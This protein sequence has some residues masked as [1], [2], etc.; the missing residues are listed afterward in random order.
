MA[1]VF[2][3]MQKYGRAGEKS[4]EQ[5]SSFLEFYNFDND[6]SQ[7]ET[8]SGEILSPT[9]AAG[10]REQ[11]NP[12]VGFAASADLQVGQALDVF[13]DYSDDKTDWGKPETFWSAP[14]QLS[15][16]RQTA[17]TN[18]EAQQS[19]L[20]AESSAEAAFTQA[21][22]AP[23]SDLLAATATEVSTDQ[24][25]ETEV[26]V[27]A[28]AE[29]EDPL[30]EITGAWDVKATESAAPET[31]VESPSPEPT[32][33]AE[34]IIA[35]A[36]MIRSAAPAPAA[37]SSPLVNTLPE[38]VRDEFRRLR[39]SLLLAAESQQLQVLMVCGVES[40]D[41]ATFVARNLSLLLAEFDKI[42]V[43]RFELG[44]LKDNS[45]DPLPDSPESYQL[46]LRKTE[47][48]NLRE[49]STPQGGVS[50]S[51]LLRLCDTR[52][53]I[54]RL[55]ERFDF[56]LIDAP[57][58]TANPDTALLASQVDGVILIAQQDETRCQA[59][60]GARAALQN[61]RANVLGVVLNRRKK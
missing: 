47:L 24:V 52:T 34:E 10:R 48:P 18:H 5:L 26:T 61:A 16:M 20:P 13:A 45:N 59:L 44:G 36:E 33:E 50:L 41:G 2:E 28:V 54:E 14:D 43:G 15:G 23:L 21:E 29:E 4:D 17:P 8:P 38:T 35:A 46:A 40:G 7:S 51:E 30:S 39:S 6:S 22:E 11:F 1:R 25:L 42:N 19:E 31:A 55:K 9:G 58:V 3:A 49:I 57:A 60:A 12:A 53:M 37:S 56:V 32:S 27:A